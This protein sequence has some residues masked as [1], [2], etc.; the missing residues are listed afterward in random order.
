MHSCSRLGGTYIVEAIIRRG[1]K[2]YLAKG[3]MVEMVEGVPVVSISEFMDKECGERAPDADGI[4]VPGETVA[5]SAL[6]IKC[7]FPP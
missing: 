1:G 4:A 3:I 2:R 7:A 5:V 6:R